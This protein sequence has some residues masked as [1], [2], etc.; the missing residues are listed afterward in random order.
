[1]N[2]PRVDSHEL[3]RS[4]PKLKAVID[5]TIYE[6]DPLV[7]AYFFSFTKERGR[8]LWGKF[9]AFQKKYGDEY[10]FSDYVTSIVDAQP[11]TKAFMPE[12]CHRPH[13]ESFRPDM[14]HLVDLLEHF[15]KDIRDTSVYRGQLSEEQL[16][17]AFLEEVYFGRGEMYAIVRKHHCVTCPYKNCTH[18]P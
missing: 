3:A 5:E 11:I 9:R 16:L 2:T 15:T 13:R 18:H 7:V 8:S 17:M 10:T 1:M 6:M 14:Q 4:N 12:G